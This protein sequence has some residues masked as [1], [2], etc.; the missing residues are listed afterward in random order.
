MRILC[1]EDENEQDDDDDYVHED[2]KWMNECQTTIPTP[3]LK[4]KTTT[5]RYIKCVLGEHNDTFLL[6]HAEQFDDLV[7]IWMLI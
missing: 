3:T 6:Q 1:H 5:S 4:A 7:G 2:G